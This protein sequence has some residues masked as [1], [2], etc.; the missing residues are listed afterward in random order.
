MLRP[1]SGFAFR[2]SE[3]ASGFAPEGTYDD[4]GAEPQPYA[5]ARVTIGQ[6]DDLSSAGRF[7]FSG[8]V[9]HVLGSG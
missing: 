2:Q 9:V 5:Q 7:D 1:M 8:L 4:A 6:L 3:V